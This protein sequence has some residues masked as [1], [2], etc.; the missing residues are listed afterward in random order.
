MAEFDVDIKDS[1]L[2]SP[3]GGQL[4]NR[5]LSYEAESVLIN[6][7]ASAVKIS[8]L[9]RQLSDVVMISTGGFFPLTGYS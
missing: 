2:G 6:N 9:P 1:L 4:I 3:H 7:T 5:V 8:L